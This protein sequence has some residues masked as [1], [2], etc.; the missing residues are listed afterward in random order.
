MQRQNQK[1]VDFLRFERCR[2]KNETAA[3][4][5]FRPIIQLT[6][7]AAKQRRKFA[8]NERFP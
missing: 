7:I 8:E 1:R 3:L 2:A 4:G 6:A 5:I